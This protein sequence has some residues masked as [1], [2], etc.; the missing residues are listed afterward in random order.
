MASPIINPGSAGTSIRDTVNIDTA[1]AVPIEWYNVSDQIYVKNFSSRPFTVLLEN[2]GAESRWNDTHSWY[3]DE[4]VPQNDTV[5]GSTSSAATTITVAD[6]S[7]FNTDDTVW[8][9]SVDAQALVTSVNVT[10]N[11]IGVAWVQAPSAN[12][13]NG[14]TIIRIGNA[15]EQDDTHNPGPT[16]KEVMKSNYFQDM[17]HGVMATVMNING[18]YR[19][20]P[21]DWTQQ[22]KKK[23]E[24]HARE[25]EKTLLFGQSALWT[26]G[27]NATT[28]RGFSQGLYYFAT[29]NS[30]TAGNI[31]LT[32]AVWDNFLASVTDKNEQENQDWW[33][34]CSSRIHQQVSQFAQPFERSNTRERQFGMYV[35]TYLAPNG[36]LVKMKTHPM[37]FQHGLHDFGI[38]VNMSKDNIKL[39]WHS[40]LATKRYESI[41]PYGR[42]SKDVFFWSVF[43]LEFKAEDINL[44]LLTDV[45][46]A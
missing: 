24:E 2:I 6:A 21:D 31:A 9:H 40:T 34:L 5:D 18:R 45:A 16:T 35:E 11:Q 41:I 44:G 20:R 19:T 36:Q 15:H 12:I 28:P 3:E 33:F 39:I 22:Q 7:K 23:M 38:L 13:A 37:F 8:I 1:G 17:R 29:T 14:A 25:K 30:T 32:R 27:V 4:L 26:T 10:T 42:S 46:A 43:T